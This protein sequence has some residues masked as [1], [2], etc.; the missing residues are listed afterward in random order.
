MLVHLA[1]ANASE[2]GLSQTIWRKFKKHTS[3]TLALQVLNDK[4]S[5]LSINLPDGQIKKMSTTT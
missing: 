1:L 4:P 2:N 3:E 5:T